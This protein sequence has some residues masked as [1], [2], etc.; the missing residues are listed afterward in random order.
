MRQSSYWLKFKKWDRQFFFTCFQ[1]TVGEEGAQ[2]VIEQACFQPALIPLTN[3]S[4]NLSMDSRSG[5]AQS[6]R[7][8]FQ[9]SR[10]SLVNIRCEIT[11]IWRMTK[12]QH[13]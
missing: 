10:M 7:I 11:V 13:P 12:L 8:T 5:P 3:P 4:N 6:L 1:W 2:F 9:C